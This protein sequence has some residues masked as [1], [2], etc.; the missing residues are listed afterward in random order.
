MLWRGSSLCADRAIG[1]RALAF[2]SQASVKT[3]LL[4]N[5][6]PQAPLVPMGKGDASHVGLSRVSSCDI[7]ASRQA[8]FALEQRLAGYLD[9]TST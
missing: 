8:L 3:Y 4:C 9:H 7:E 5:V 1:F 2:Y 6:Y